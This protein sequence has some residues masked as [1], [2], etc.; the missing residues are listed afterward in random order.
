MRI[1]KKAK[2]EQRG[3]YHLC[4]IRYLASFCPYPE[5][6]IEDEF[7]DTGL[8]SLVFEGRRAFSLRH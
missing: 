8:M 7:K 6:L 1:C 4:E 5:N 3:R 2:T